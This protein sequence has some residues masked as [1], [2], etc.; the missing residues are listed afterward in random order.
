MGR[1]SDIFDKLYE[2]YEQGIIPLFGEVLGFVK[3][4]ELYSESSGL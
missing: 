3:G 2:M 1:V 4:Q